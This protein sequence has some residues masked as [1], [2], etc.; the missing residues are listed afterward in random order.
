MN[1]KTIRNYTIPRLCFHKGD[2]TKQWYVYFYFR[3]NTGKRKQFRYKMGI[4]YL[5]TKK[6]RILE[7]NAIIQAL[8]T[9]LQDGWNPLTKEKEE[10]REDKTVSDRLDEILSIKSAYITPRSRK[11]YYDQINLFK[12]WLKSSQINHLYS[13]NL[14]SSHVRKYLDWLLG[15]KRYSGKTYNSHLTTLKS[16]FNEMVERNYMNESPAKGFKM[17]REEVGK[18]TTYS[19]HEEK[20]FDATIKGKE[21]DFYL[22]T[23]FVR[24]L[25]LRRSELSQLQVKHINWQS[26]TIVIPSENSKNRNQDS[27]TIPQT[28]EKLII[29]HR[30]LELGPEMYIFGKDFKPSLS[31]LKRVDDLTDCQREINRAL[32]IKNECTFYSWKHTG[33]VELYQR[34]KDVY[35]VMRQCRHSDIKM[36]MRYLRSLGCMVSEQVREW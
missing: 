23:R 19:E 30:L 27:V 6:E 13:Q 35:V 29:K 10:V 36:T 20:L 24:Y 26:K 12:K 18:N 15:V 8:S 2:M 5:E 4:N 9:K 25:F 21:Q 34:T 31:K 17:V 22:A 3:D 7:A 11:T 1:M 32:G 28:L 33:A 14:T 16:F